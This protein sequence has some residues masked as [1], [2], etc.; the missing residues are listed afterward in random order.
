VTG[1]GVRWKENELPNFV[2]T[3]TQLDWNFTTSSRHVVSHTLFP[4]H[5]DLV[6]VVLGKSQSSLDTV[7]C[8]YS[9]LHTLCCYSLRMKHAGSCAILS[10]SQLGF[11]SLYFLG[12]YEDCNI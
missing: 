6:D 8:T 4:S 2:V 10:H 11:C 7:T 1:I 5:I 9:H 12:C 3:D